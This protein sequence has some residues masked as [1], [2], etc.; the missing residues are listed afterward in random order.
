MRCA[1]SEALVRTM[2]DA[3]ERLAIVTLNLDLLCKRAALAGDP[4]AARFARMA[5]EAVDLAADVMLGLA[6]LVQRE[7]QEAA[8]DTSREVA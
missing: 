3:A 8:N 5:V 6:L 2:T 1:E 7:S 4:Q